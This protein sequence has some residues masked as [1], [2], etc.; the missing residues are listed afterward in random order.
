MPLGPRGGW[1][2]T[3]AE[4]GLESSDLCGAA[5]AAES[6]ATQA[7]GCPLRKNGTFF[8]VWESQAEVMLKG[9]EKVAM[10]GSR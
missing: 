7:S 9:G 3:Q 2:S 6:E 1:E 4:A 5:A 8:S 10:G